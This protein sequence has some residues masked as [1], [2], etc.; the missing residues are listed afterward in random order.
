MMRRLQSIHKRVHVY[1]QAQATKKTAPFGIICFLW[2][3]FNFTV[4]GQRK[5]LPTLNVFR[6]LQPF[7]SVTPYFMISQQPCEL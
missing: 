1:K 5:C 4:F 3:R 7:S 2:T 6:T